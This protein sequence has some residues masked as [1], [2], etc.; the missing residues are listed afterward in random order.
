MVEGHRLERGGVELA[1][2]Q[3]EQGGFQEIQSPEQVSGYWQ[4]AA[5][6]CRGCTITE[7]A[8]L[9]SCTKKEYRLFSREH[10]QPLSQRF[11]QTRPGS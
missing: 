7:C 10:L 2:H 4:A 8:A 5:A 3:G 1:E 9:L 6:A 11:V